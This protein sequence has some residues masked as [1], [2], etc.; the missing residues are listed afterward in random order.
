MLSQISPE[1]EYVFFLFLSNQCKFEA[2]SHALLSFSGKELEMFCS[3][4]DWNCS[5][6]KWQI[7][8][9][10]DFIL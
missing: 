3:Q 2:V 6:S 7:E 10:L 1:L 8:A 9:D 5:L 4:F